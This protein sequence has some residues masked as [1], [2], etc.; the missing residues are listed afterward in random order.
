MSMDGFHLA[1]DELRRLGQLDRKGATDTF[2]AGGFVH[3]L[4]RLHARDEAVVYAPR[5]DRSLEES[6]GSAVPVPAEMPMI[7]VEGNYLLH[8]EPGLERR[9]AACSTSAGTSSRARR[10]G[11]PG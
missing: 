5:F 2:D 7:I 9:R 3:L 11:W 4:R 10:C 8:D 6:I 1:D